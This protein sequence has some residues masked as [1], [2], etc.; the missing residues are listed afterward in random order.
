MKN[1]MSIQILEEE[2]A[3]KLEKVEEEIMNKGLKK[4]LWKS[5]Y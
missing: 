1:K 2:R 4:K 5:L 3:S